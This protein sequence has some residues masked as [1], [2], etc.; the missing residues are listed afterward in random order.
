MKTH[1]DQKAKCNVFMKAHVDLSG[2]VDATSITTTQ[3]RHSQIDYKQHTDPKQHLIT[4]LNLVCSY[5]LYNLC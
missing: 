2:F 3:S 4:T 1:V 5:Y